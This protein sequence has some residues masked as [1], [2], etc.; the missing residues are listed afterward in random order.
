MKMKIFEIRKKNLSLLVEETGG[1]TALAK[2]LKKSQSQISQ[3]LMKK[4]TRKIGDKLAISIEKHF[5]KPR[6]WLDLENVHIQYSVVPLIKWTEI[7]K[8]IKHS[9]ANNQ[10]IATQPRVSSK[11]FALQ[12]FN[13]TMES[14]HSISFPKHSIVIV[15]PEKPAE[16]DSFAIVQDGKSN[17]AILRQLI[18]EGNHIYLKPLNPLYPLTKLNKKPVV[19]GVV[20]GIRLAIE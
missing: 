18:F 2:H 15:D 14:T 10:L 9:L 19:Y 11:S 13:D 20:C 17:S 6:G 8:D 1:I 12:I 4:S 7:T 16:P 3:L 5:K